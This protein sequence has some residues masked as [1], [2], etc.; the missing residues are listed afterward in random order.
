MEQADSVAIG[1][2]LVEN[3]VT[4]KLETIEP[5]DD[6]LLMS[7]DDTNVTLL[8][9][10]LVD[11]VEDVIEVKLGLLTVVETKPELEYEGEDGLARTELAGL[12]LLEDTALKLLREI[13]LV[14]TEL[15]ENIVLVVLELSENI[16]LLL[17]EL[18]E[19][20]VLELLEDVIL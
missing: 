4:G 1:V 20:T 14:L 10:E 7:E 15:F 9:K 5:E 11:E 8:A 3:E 16:V 2:E 18:P 13:V 12:V 17:L 6:M 19:T